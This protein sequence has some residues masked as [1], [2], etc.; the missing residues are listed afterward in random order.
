MKNQTF[1]AKIYKKKEAREHLFL[2][3]LFSN[4]QFFNDLTVSVDFC[5]LQVIQQRSS[6]TYQFH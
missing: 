4:I 6:F 1:S 2:E 5:F 3:I